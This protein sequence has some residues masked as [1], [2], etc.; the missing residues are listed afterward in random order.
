VAGLKTE[1]L[2]DG[3]LMKELDDSGFINQLYSAYGV[4]P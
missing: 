4:K 3:N 2:I 1:N